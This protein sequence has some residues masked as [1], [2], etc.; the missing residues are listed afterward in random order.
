MVFSI[1]KDLEHILQFELGIFTCIMFLSFVV[2]LY[3]DFKGSLCSI[4]ISF[5]TEELH[6]PTWYKTPRVVLMF[7]FFGLWPS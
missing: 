5:T 3:T 4:T 6:F 1:P 7:F 2:K